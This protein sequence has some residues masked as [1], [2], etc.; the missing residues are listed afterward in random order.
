M[1]HTPP[2]LLNRKATR[3]AADARRGRLGA[4][5]YNHLVQRLAH[6]IR[7]AFDAG[8]IGSPW[9]FEG[10]LRAGIRADLCLQGWRWPDADAAAFDLLGDAFRIVCPNRP[11]WDEGQPEWAIHAGLLIERTIC[12]RCKRPLPEGHFKF[13]GALCRSAHS[14]AI[15]AIKE[16]Q[17]G[18]AYDL[19]TQRSLRVVGGYDTGL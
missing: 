15:A 18:E 16:A 14:K 13:C 9:G 7:Q 5:R 8:A 11:G 6:V 19:V 2:H 12:V 1:L 10:P 4:G 17:E 3:R